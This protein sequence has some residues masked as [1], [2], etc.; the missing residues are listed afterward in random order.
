[1]LTVT[2]FYWA[3]SGLD[4]TG[5]ILIL[6]FCTLGSSDSPSLDADFRHSFSVIIIGAGTSGLS[7][8]TTLAEGGVKDFI[9]LEGRDRVGG[10]IQQDLR[11][12]CGIDLGASWIHGV[13][14][15]P[16]LAVAER[17]GLRLDITHNANL[18]GSDAFKIYGPDGHKLEPNMEASARAKFDEMNTLARQLLD[19]MTNE[20]DVSVAQLFQLATEK[21]KPKYTEDEKD[22]VNWLKSGI[23]GWENSN[24]DQISARDHIDEEDGT[25]YGGGDAFVI[26]GY[27]HIINHL[28]SK[29]EGH[30]QT[31][32][33]ALSIVYNDNGVTVTTNRGDFH[34]DYCIITVPLGVLKANAIQ[35]VPPLPKEKQR[36]IENIGFG[37]MN[38][39]VLQFDEV[40]W[41]APA[42]GFGYV[43]NI[44]GEFSFF[45]N[46]CPLLN[47]PILMCFIAADFA[48]EVENWR[49]E[50]VI[51]RIMVVLRSIFGR[52]KEIPLPTVYRITRWKADRFSRGSYSFI[53]AGCTT[54]DVRSLGKPVG[55]LHFSGEATFK[56]VGYVHGAYITGQRE[57][58]KI[59]AD[60]G[61]DDLTNLTFCLNFCL[62]DALGIELRQ[63]QRGSAWYY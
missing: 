41:E 24:L 58:Q 55:R 3:A 34:A 12:G 1:M 35:F 10:R 11:F 4:V 30:I 32:T 2:V 5:S 19:S 40:F 50:A 57:A 61:S 46:L 39:I 60:M 36:A 59:M 45:L 48:H 44:H 26:D 20:K 25:A 52:E 42:E 37:L 53:K 15:N 27:H 18:T 13:E 31:D 7:A 38:K 51:E 54:K 21:M 33:E 9:I 16:V 63:L 14:G 17:L 8:A 56:R 49:D 28:A 6:N 62:C 43:S 23:E 47:K 22:F 29:I